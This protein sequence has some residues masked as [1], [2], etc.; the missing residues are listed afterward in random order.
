VYRGAQRRGRC[1]PFCIFLHTRA[2][3]FAAF[4]STLP[5][6]FGAALA[7]VVFMAH[8]GHGQTADLGAVHVEPDATFHHLDVIFSETRDGAMVTF[9]GTLFACT[10]A[11]LMLV[12]GH[13]ESSDSCWCSCFVDASPAR[14]AHSMSLIIRGA[15]EMR[16]RASA[17]R[18]L[19]D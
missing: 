4:F 11:L 15:F 5:A 8:G 19:G 9:L 12:V 13:G 14:A 10:N 7:M 1:A 16:Y 17:D 18:G 3:H 6:R 2:S